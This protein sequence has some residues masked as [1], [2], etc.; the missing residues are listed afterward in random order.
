MNSFRWRMWVAIGALGFY[1]LCGLATVLAVAR[2]LIQG[3]VAGAVLALGAFGIYR[4]AL[5][6]AKYSKRSCRQENLPP[7]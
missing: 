6:V 3:F 5:R 4:A 1:V 7:P 2:H